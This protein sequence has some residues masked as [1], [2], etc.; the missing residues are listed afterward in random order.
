[1][2]TGDQ[3]VTPMAKQ[4]A[5]SY[6]HIT[7]DPREADAALCFI[8]SPISIAGGDPLE[9]SK[10]RGYKGK[11][12]TAAN[13]EDLDLILN[14]RKEMGEK[15]VIAIVTLKNPMVMAEFEP[16]TDAILVEYGV[17]PAAVLDV[18]TGAFDP[19]G[20]LPIQ[21]PKDMETVEQIGRAH[22]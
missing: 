10:D 20:L 22:V 4:V 19:E 16:Y 11:W 12:N 18:L 6:F 7:E 5:A 3:T 15:P 9:A 8:E 21:I 14:M 13:E 17:T 2:P 1:M